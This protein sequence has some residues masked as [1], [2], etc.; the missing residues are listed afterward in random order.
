LLERQRNQPDIPM[1]FHALGGARNQVWQTFT[2]SG[3]PSAAKATIHR[4]A[5]SGNDDPRNGLALTPDAH[6]MFDAGL[7]TVIPK[8][9]DLLIHV[10]AG[11]FSESSPHGRLLSQFHDQPLSFHSHA[12]LR[13]DAKHFDWHR[14]AKFSART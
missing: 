4:H 12:R 2:A 1:P 6:W 8:G 9:D 11:R 3:E 14:T 13:P 7:W 10:A 5:L